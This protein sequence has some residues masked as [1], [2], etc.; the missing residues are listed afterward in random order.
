MSDTS[1]ITRRNFIS[2]SILQTAATSVAHAA[3]MPSLVSLGETAETSGVKS[4]VFPYGAVYFRKSNRLPK[5]AR[6]ITRQPLAAAVEPQ[7]RINN[8]SVQARLHQG[9]GGAYLWVTNPTRS[10]QTVTVSLS[11]EARGFKSA[12]DIWGKQ[13]IKLDGRQLTLDVS[14]RDAAVIA[15]S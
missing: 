7:V 15:L 13:P 5:T 1:G 12:E 10:S 3:G 4:P 2:N 8:S 11:S 14:A 9:T 6:A